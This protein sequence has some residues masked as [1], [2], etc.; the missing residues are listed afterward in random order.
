MAPERNDDASL[1]ER[2]Y[3]DEKGEVHVHTKFYVKHDGTRSA[4]AG[5]GWSNGQGSRRRIENGSR[6]AS[7]HDRL[8]GLFLVALKDIYS[9]QKQMLRVMWSMGGQIQSD[10][11]RQVL[12]MHGEE[13]ETQVERLEQV[14]EML[15]KPAGGKACK[16][17]EALINE[18]RVVVE[19]FKGSDA[20]DAR[21]ISAA[22]A[23]ERYEISCYHTLK[24]WA[25]ELG[26][27]DALKLLDEMLQEEKR[28]D[29]ILTQL[30]EQRVDQRAA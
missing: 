4:V 25:E 16:T 19:K 14:F 10:Q 13:T 20:L 26:M 7:V 1:Q 28:T 8:G 30:A 22:R 17:I 12:E 11:L 3:R 2:D 24:T 5:D 15:N 9:A 23:I 21:L 18:L 29:A 6:T 27:R